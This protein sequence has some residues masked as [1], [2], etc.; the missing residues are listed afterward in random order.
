MEPHD[1]HCRRSAMPAG[2]K[3]GC[4]VCRNVLLLHASTHTSVKCMCLCVQY[5]TDTNCNANQKKNWPAATW[6]LA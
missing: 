6:Q 5:I 1:G 2:K 3:L 4:V